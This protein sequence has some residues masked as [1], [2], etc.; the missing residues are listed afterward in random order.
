MFAL[1]FSVWV[2]MY[3]QRF[4]HLGAHGIA[5]QRIATP[6]AIAT[7]LPEHVN[8]PSN[9]L[10][11]LFEMPVLF[12]ALCAIAL[13]LHLTDSLLV[14]LAWAYVGLRV[15]HSAIHCTTNHVV[16]RFMAYFASCATLV[17]MLARLA[18]V[19]P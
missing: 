11:N 7:L 14:T 12:Y 19:A 15:V 8:R 9:N 2:F 4:R 18:L 16:I 6:E 17:A 10:K 5:P 13:A 1:T 3:V